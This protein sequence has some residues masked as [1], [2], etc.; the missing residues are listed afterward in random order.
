Y[1]IS[2]VALMQVVCIKRGL[3]LAPGQWLSDTSWVGTLFLVS[4]VVAGVL[5]LNP[6]QFGRS[7][8][9]VGMLVI[10]LSLALLPL[11]FPQQIAE[12]EAQEARVAA[13]EREAQQNQKRFHAAFTQA[14]I[15]MAIV[16][17]DGAVVQ[18]NQALCALLG[19]GEAQL[20]GR[21][22]D[23]LL[24]PSDATLLSRHVAGVSERRT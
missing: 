11:H 16:S 10:G 18:A 22:F 7:P 13:A 14:S 17:P 2:T 20:H 5:S 23:C 9:A 15:G 12:H 21:P 19:Y 3:R 6:Q 8:A 1:A 24:H 4:A